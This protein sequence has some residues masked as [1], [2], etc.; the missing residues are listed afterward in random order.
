[1][2]RLTL[3]RKAV[4]AVVLCLCCRAAILLGQAPDDDADAKRLIEVLELH[5][6]SVVADIGAG[7]GPLTIRIARNVG[8][9]GKVYSTDLNE[10][11]LREIREAAAKAQLQNVVVMEGGADR[12]NLPEQCCDAIFMRSVYHHFGHP[13]V[14]NASL[15]ASLKP[16]GRLAVVD[17][18]PDSGVSAPPGRRANGKDHGVTVETVLEELKAAGFIDVQQ[19]TWS[20][21]PFLVTGRRPQ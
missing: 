6:G 10:D 16:G 1:M 8:P 17:F 21:G 13:P 19:T 3:G 20:P 18:R 5:D 2:M 9:T 15:L 11:R 7:S 12:T 4:V 14:M